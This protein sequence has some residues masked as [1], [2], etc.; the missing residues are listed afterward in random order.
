MMGGFPLFPRVSAYI[1]FFLRTVSASLSLLKSI[2]KRKES[3]RA[4]FVV[5]LNVKKKGVCNTCRCC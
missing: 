3:F 5:N 2:Q 1:F 4:V